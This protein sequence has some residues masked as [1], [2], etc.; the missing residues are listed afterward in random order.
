M[1][2]EKLT[3]EEFEKF[4]ADYYVDWIKA[5]IKLTHPRDIAAVTPEVIEDESINRYAI[6]CVKTGQDIKILT[7][8][9]SLRE[10][11]LNTAKIAVVRNIIDNNSFL[12]SAVAE[13]MVNM[14]ETLK[15]IPTGEEEANYL[16]NILDSTS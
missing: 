14:S 5:I 16:Q 11:E 15:S 3:K 1:N 9:P 8:N 12:I 6:E 7:Y 13:T 10:G 4:I 2:R